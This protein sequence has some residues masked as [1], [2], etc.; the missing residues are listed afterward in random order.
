M[1]KK[2]DSLKQRFP[3][4]PKSLGNRSEVTEIT[5]SQKCSITLYQ[6]DLDILDKIREYLRQKGIRNLSD[7]EALR[8]AC[9]TVSVDDRLIETYEVMKLDDGRRRQA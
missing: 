4:S 7:S 5:A 9:R 2:S 1:K 3:K 6:R 8:L